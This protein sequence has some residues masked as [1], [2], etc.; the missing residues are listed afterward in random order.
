[1]MRVGNGYDIHRFRTAGDDVL[2][3]GG[4]DVPDAL[5]LDGYSD[6]DALIHAIIDAVLGAAGE[7]DIG[8]H[9]PPG[10][11]EYR[12]IDSRELLRRV[13]RLIASRGFRVKNVDATVIAE[14]P[15]LAAHLGAM[16]ESLA[17]ALGV[18]PRQVNVKATTNEGLGAIG[19]GEAIAA[20]AVAL[21]DDEVP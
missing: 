13:T 17:L 5:R 21:L 15:R 2:R 6:G 11:P 20:L 19:A 16:R 10:D 18:E 12:D 8:H 9:F 14:R 4:I 7:G 3:L 1:M